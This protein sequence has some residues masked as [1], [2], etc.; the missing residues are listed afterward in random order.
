M[1]I[2]KD[3]LS[4]PIFSIV[5]DN[6]NKSIQLW[7]ANRHSGEPVRVVWG[8]RGGRMILNRYHPYHQRLK[9]TPFIL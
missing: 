1:L 2:T 9:F 6:A 3:A 4:H 8:H 7:I 5:A